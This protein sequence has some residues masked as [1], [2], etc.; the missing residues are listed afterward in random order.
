MHCEATTEL[1]LVI[2]RTGTCDVVPSDAPFSARFAPQGATRY[3]R[4]KMD[5][6]LDHHQRS[7][8]QVGELLK[9]LGEGQTVATAALQKISHDTLLQAAEDLDLFV[10]MGINPVSRD[11]VST[12]SMNVATLAI[13]LGATLGLNEQ[14]LCDLG[15][16]C[17]VHDAGMLH[18]DQTL[19]K[20]E[21][22]LD[23]TEF[24]EIAKHS[25]IATDLLYERM[26]QVPLGVRMIVYQMHERCDGS[27]YPRGI[28]G[29][30]IHPL[31]KISAV[32]DAYVALVSQRPHRPAMLPYYAMTR[33][34]EDVRAGLFDSSVVRGLLNTISLFPIGSFVELETGQVAK[35]I[36]A[37][38]T[39]YD[40]PIAET[41][42]RD[43]LKAAPQVVDL[44]EEGVRVVK[45]LTSLR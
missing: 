31:S 6:F 11:S 3:E 15:I 17:L 28:T 35:I 23:P 25:M 4:E 30:R 40:R 42:Y 13:A 29:D 18:V 37:N 33:M 10:C 21:R 19:Y 45:A 44:S 24:V 2:E 38:G 32:A 16:G 27:G 39:A 1:D 5:H 12:H 41:W 34:L 7:A 43:R 9:Q 14:S 8:E 22:V 26:E 36:R 20:S